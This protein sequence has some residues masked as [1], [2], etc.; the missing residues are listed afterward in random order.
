MQTAEP[1]L[2]KRMKFPLPPRMFVRGENGFHSA[3]WDLPSA[4]SA[5]Q[6]GGWFD[7]YAEFATP[8]V[9]KFAHESHQFFS[10]LREV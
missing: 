10:L 5:V 6:A 3:P 4:L 2:P 7:Q 1:T 9:A 8:E